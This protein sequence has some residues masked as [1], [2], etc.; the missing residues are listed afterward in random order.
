MSPGRFITLEGGEGVGKTS[1]LEAIAGHLAARGV[2]LVTT[3]EPGGTL[4]GEALRELLLRGRGLRPEAELLMMFA[5]RVQHV[6]DV[7]MPALVAGRWVLSDR[8]TDASYAYQGGGRGIA[9]G[10]I[11][12]LET[13][14]LSGL[15]PDLTLL[16]DAPVEIGMQRVRQRGAMDRFESE[17]ADFQQRVRQAYRMRAQAFPE[18]I[19]VIDAA[20]AI[21]RVREDI[22]RELERR[23]A[24]DW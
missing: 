7:I 5:A 3:R 1:S 22:V 11:E 18:R 6:H 23:F 13:W 4:L 19:R 8:Y 16:L 20:R 24:N 9:P 2:E 21:D 14:A 15:R 17:S 10:T 12:F